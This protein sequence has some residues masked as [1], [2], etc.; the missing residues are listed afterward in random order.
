MTLLWAGL[1]LGVTTGLLAG[2]RLWRLR[3]A[4]IR[5]QTLLLATLG[6]SALLQAGLGRALPRWGALGLWVC[7]G[8][9]GTLVA[10]V[11]FRRVGLLMVGLGLLMNVVVVGLNGGMPVMIDAAVPPT[12]ASSMQDAISNSW[13]YV[14]L[15]ESTRLSLLA[16]VLPIPGPAATRGLASL[17]DVFIACGVAV[18][19]WMLMTGADAGD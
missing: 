13:L 14:E 2:G 8:A 16:D 9:V 11:N 19:S 3:N 10:L 6:V 5:G 18:Y 15:G 12:F 1:L 4:T 17:G 7:V